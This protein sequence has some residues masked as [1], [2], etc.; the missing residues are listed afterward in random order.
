MA[1]VVVVNR[2]AGEVE[3][4]FDREGEALD[5]ANMGISCWGSGVMRRM[6]PAG[7]LRRVRTTVLWTLESA[8][9]ASGQVQAFDADISLLFLWRCLSAAA[10][11]VRVLPL[12][13][14]LASALSG[15]KSCVV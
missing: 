14:Y 12:I 2:N 13:Y 3:L 1:R 11:L 6:P 15:L 10:L 4:A 5:C 7:G 9:N 8:T